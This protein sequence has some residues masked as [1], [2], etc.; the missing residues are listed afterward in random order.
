MGV[1]KEI[2][3]EGDGK[4]FPKKGDKLT[5]TFFSWLLVPYRSSRICVPQLLLILFY[6]CQPIEILNILSR[7]AEVHR[8]PLVVCMI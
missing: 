2:I 6:V 4:T 3:A 7:G 1:T 5:S 8:M